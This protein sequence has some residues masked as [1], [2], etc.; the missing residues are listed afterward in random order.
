MYKKKRLDMKRR[1]FSPKANRVEL[2]EDN[3]EDDLD[4]EKS[5]HDGVKNRRHSSDEGIMDF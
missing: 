2:E 3:S 5:D 1:G 4:E